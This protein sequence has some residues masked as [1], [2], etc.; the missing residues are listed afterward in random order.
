MDSGVM[1]QTEY[2]ASGD[3]IVY[4]VIYRAWRGPSSGP[5]WVLPKDTILWQRLARFTT[6]GERRPGG[7]RFRALAEEQTRQAR[8]YMEAPDP[9]ALSRSIE[10]RR[11]R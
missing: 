6:R 5:G 10:E 9:L 4:R 8:H 1:T 2:A 3:G 7:P 11:R